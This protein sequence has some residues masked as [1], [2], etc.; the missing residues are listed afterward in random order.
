MSE[1]RETNGF[2]LYLVKGSMPEIVEGQSET[3]GYRDD[4]NGVGVF[5][6]Y[7][8]KT[9]KWVSNYEFN[10]QSLVFLQNRGMNNFKDIDRLALRGKI[11]K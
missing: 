8:Q 4:Y 3:H 11:S 1:T 9:N 5:V 7:N 6:R 10:G 2:A